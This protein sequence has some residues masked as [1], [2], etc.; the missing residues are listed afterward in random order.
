MNISVSVYLTWHIKKRAGQEKVEP[1]I[2]P[3][4]KDFPYPLDSKN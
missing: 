4:K 3:D 2:Y 1:A